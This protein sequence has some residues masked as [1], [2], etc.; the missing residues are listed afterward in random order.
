MTNTKTYDG[1]KSASTVPTITSGTVATGDTPNF[2]VKFDSPNVGTGL[3]LTLA[4]AR[5]MTATAGTNYMRTCFDAVR[6][7]RNRPKH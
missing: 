4:R 1:T 6:Y 7:R 3:T 2:S 5:S